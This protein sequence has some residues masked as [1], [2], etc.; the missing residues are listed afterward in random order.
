MGPSWWECACSVTPSCLTLWDPMDC[1]PP[2]SS[3]H[4]IL[5]SSILEWVAMPS[6][7]GY[8]WPRDQTCISCIT[9]GFFT[10]WATGR[11]NDGNS[12][13]IIRDIREIPSSCSL[14]PF[15][16]DT[17]RRWPSASQGEDPQQ[18][19][20]LPALWSWNSQ[21]PGL[22]EINVCCLNLSVYKILLWKPK[23]AKT[24]SFLGSVLEEM[25]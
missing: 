10:I 4:G 3:V 23:M 11:L 15:H 18:E 13:F 16:E 7:R 21:P 14:S 1:S 6:P 17:V 24:V 9:G 20:N 2:T 19:V 22:G 25:G 12:A 5:Q 8:S